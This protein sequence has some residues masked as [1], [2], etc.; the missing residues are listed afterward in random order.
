MSG[1]PPQREIFAQAYAR[2]GR[3]TDAYREAY[4]RSKS[5][6]KSQNEMASRLLADVKVFSRVEELRAKIEDEAIADA[7]ERRRFW[8]TVMRSAEADMKDRLKASELSGKADGDFVDRK[9]LQNPDGSPIML[10][11]GKTRQQ[12]IDEA[13]D[14]GISAEELGLEEEGQE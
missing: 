2:H 8:T 14:W 7:K 1:L 13:K 12:I 9:I 11:A 3:A 5:K 6:A 4:P 10:P